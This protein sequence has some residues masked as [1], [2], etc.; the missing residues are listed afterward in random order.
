MLEEVNIRN[1]IMN[2]SNNSRY[3]KKYSFLK[4]IIGYKDLEL[5]FIFYL[6]M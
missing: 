6:R 2:D 4:N 1:H 3:E 5:E